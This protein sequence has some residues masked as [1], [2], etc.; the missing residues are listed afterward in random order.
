[1]SEL[2]E[3][4]ERA[5]ELGNRLQTRLVVS[6]NGDC[7]VQEHYAVQDDELRGGSPDRLLVG[8]LPNNIDRRSLLVS[9]D[10]RI[11]TTPLVLNWRLIEPL[12]DTDQW[13]QAM[14]NCRC[15]VRTKTHVHT[16]TLEQQTALSV[17]VRDDDGNLVSVDRTRVESLTVMPP[18]NTDM[19]QRTRNCQLL[20]ALSNRAALDTVL[21]VGYALDNTGAQNTMQWEAQH[22]LTLSADHQQLVWRTL[23]QLKNQTPVDYPQCQVELLERRSDRRP[24]EYQQQPYQHKQASGRKYARSRAVETTEMAPAVM[25]PPAPLA[26]VS[27]TG[28]RRIALSQSIKLLGSSECTVVGGD[29]EPLACRFRSV[30][31]ALAPLDDDDK[32]RD[33]LRL[34]DWLKQ[35]QDKLRLQGSKT[36]RQLQ[37]SGYAVCMAANNRPLLESVTS[38][39]WLDTWQDKERVRLQ[40]GA[41]SEVRVQRRYVGQERFVE[42]RRSV[43]TMRVDVINHSPSARRVRLEELMPRN[44]Y[45]L[46]VDGLWDSV[47]DQANSLYAYQTG[48][49]ANSALFVKRA[50]DQT[51][52]FSEHRPLDSYDDLVDPSLRSLDFV[53]VAAHLYSPSVC[54]LLYKV[55]TDLL[56]RN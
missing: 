51:P 56:D 39:Y 20:V 45:S 49:S 5:C 17:I 46:K 7:T 41:G 31:R 40:L 53:M 44:V 13:L 42:T 27:E 32:P 8:S 14:H 9:T 36:Q 23:V 3:E 15:T 16:G 25:A 47:A 48:F 50:A 43:V 24:T 52:Q 55:E 54:T 28:S 1:M 11:T 29:Y 4:L 37:P 21:Q 33:T 35:E 6:S 12:L 34:L 30:A 19:T 22:V 26:E 38:R 18:P 10:R 2:R